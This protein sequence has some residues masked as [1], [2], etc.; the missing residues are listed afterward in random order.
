MFLVNLD[1][2]WDLKSSIF[3]IIWQ[4]TGKEFGKKHYKRKPHPS[5]RFPFGRKLLP[6]LITFFI[7]VFLSNVLS[8]CNKY[9]MHRDVAG[10]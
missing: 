6:L 3:H 10:C 5:Y 1:E 2:G 8:T 4:P 7:G 9:E